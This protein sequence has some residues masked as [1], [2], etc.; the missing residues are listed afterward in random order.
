MEVQEINNIGDLAPL[1]DAWWELLRVTTDATFFHTPE[2]LEAY[3]EH[4]GR[5]QKLRVFVVRDRGAC[6]GIL[7]LVVRVQRTRLGR[8]RFLTYPLDDWGSF[9]GPISANPSAVHREVWSKVVKDH[10]DWD[11]VE[12]RWIGHRLEEATDLAQQFSTLGMNGHITLTDHS[13]AVVFSGSWEDYLA[14]K[15]SKWRNNLKRWERNLSKSGELTFERHRPNPQSGSSHI[16]WDLFDECLKVARASWQSQSPDGT[17]LCHESIRSF[18]TDVHTAAAR[19][20]GI[21]LNLLRIDDRPI[22]FAYNYHLHGKLCGLRVGFD[23]E[24]G[25]AGA[26]NLLYAKV[27]QDSF[28]RADLWYD[29]GAGSLDCKRYFA[30][31]IREIYR[32]T[33]SSARSLRGRLISMKRKREAVQSFDDQATAAASPPLNSL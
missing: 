29:L 24:F 16:R 21:D 23:A 30:S 5:G 3:W 27:I 28:E 17:T 31:E 22:A 19:V 18:L 7:P 14:S 20:G 10:H 6:I 1:R 13:P 25:R 2:W 4:Y 9:Y 26:G 12:P 15:S 32:W 8:L 11:L 33:Y